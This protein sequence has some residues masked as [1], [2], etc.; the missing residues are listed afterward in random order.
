VNDPEAT[1]AHHLDAWREDSVLLLDSAK[2]SPYLKTF[3]AA[4]KP[5]QI[6]PVGGDAASVNELERRLD[7]KA[8]APVTWT[9]PIDDSEMVYIP[10]GPFYVGPKKQQA[11]SA[12]FSLG[13]HPV[14]DAQF[15]RFR[16]GTITATSKVRR[17]GRNSKWCQTQNRYYRLGMPAPSAEAAPC[18]ARAPGPPP[19]VALPPIPSAMRVAH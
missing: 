18:A 13:R 10:A 11:V 8:A 5:A 1:L 16:D 14:T 2:L 15:Q 4:Y 17:I 9:N 3:L 12:G 19:G 6:V 7:I